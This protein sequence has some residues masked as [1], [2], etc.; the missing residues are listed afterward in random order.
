MFKAKMVGAQFVE[1]LLVNKKK[2][3]FESEKRS[4][5]SCYVCPGCGHIELIADHPTDLQMN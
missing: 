4:T 1:I 3:I 2:G 5:V